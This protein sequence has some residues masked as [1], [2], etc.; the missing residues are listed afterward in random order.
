MEYCDYITLYPFIT[1]FTFGVFSPFAYT[2]A[3]NIA[4]P[5]F[6]EINIFKNSIL[7]YTWCF[8]RI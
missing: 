2:A 6:V 1:W 8:Q 7:I 4:V 5:I 3:V